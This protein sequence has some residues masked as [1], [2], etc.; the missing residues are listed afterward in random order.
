MQFSPNAA[1]TF[2]LDRL[3]ALTIAPGESVFVPL[4]SG[5]Y[6]ARVIDCDGLVRF[7]DTAG[8]LLEE[9]LTLTVT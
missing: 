6:D 5:V 2:G 8:T 1:R 9:D 7:E 3:G 4:V